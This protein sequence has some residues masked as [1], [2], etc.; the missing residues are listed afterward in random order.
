MAIE[1][2]LV[3]FT[4][5]TG[6]GG[7]IVASIALDLLFGAKRAS[8]TSFVAG[9]TAFAFLVAG[10]L[11]SVLHLQH[12]DRILNALSHPTSGIFIEA[13]LV[14]LCALATFVF[15]VALKRT[16]NRVVHAA[17]AVIAGVLG[18]LLAFM[19]GHSYLMA[20]IPA[21]NTYLLP[22]GYLLSSAPAGIAAY[23]FLACRFEKEAA[24]APLLARFLLAAGVA[25]GLAVL[26]YGFIAANH[27]ATVA[28]W[29]CTAVIGGLVPAACAF[30]AIRKP[31]QLATL[32]AVAFACAL[33]ATILFRCAM[34]LSGVA[35][36]DL[37][38][39]I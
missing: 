8:R 25:S 11:A 4:A 36:L 1:W 7:W 34:W 37:F 22:I 30:A 16:E 15:L 12:P 14:G 26:A 24:K 27:G 33:V 39:N 35:T 20:S 21:W 13:V 10:G 2:P 19:A 23:L 17:L 18:I 5:L 3:V 9:V 38:G 32:A 29:I 28:L 31:Q 6:C